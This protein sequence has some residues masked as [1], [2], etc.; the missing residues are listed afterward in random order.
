MSERGSFT[1]EYIYCPECYIA[2]KRELNNGNFQVIEHNE[3]P[4][5]CGKA[6]GLFANEE[7]FEFEH[8]I[9]PKLEK[10]LCKGHIIKVAVLCD[11]GNSEI[12]TVKGL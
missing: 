1:T 7:L 8:H 3:S 12:F 11:A 9:K 10:G 6:G 2:A 4:I 5:V